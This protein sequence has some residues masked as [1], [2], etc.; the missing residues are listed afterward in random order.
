MRHY[1]PNRFRQPMKRSNPE[2][3]P[4]VDPKWVPISWDEALSRIVHERQIVD[5]Q[6][7]GMH[8]LE[9]AGRID[10]EFFVASKGPRR[11]HGQERPNPFA[12]GQQ[13]VADRP[14]EL[15]GRL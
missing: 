5:D 1:D 9:G 13:T 11:Q 4:N 7:R 6:R 12:G 10:G 8:H 14:M 15:L 3:G 2:K